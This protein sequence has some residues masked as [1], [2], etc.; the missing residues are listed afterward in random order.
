MQAK[1]FKLRMVTNLHIGSGESNFNFIDNQVQRDPI[2]EYPN[3]HSSGLKGALR[4]FFRGIESKNIIEF[5]G[6]E[7]NSDSASQGGLS[8]IEGKLLA[9]P[10]RSNKKSY[11]LGTTKEIIKEYIEFAK[12][13]GKEYEIDLSKIN[14]KGKEKVCIIGEKIAGITIE[15]FEG[16]EIIAEASLKEKLKEILGTEDIVIMEETS[17]KEEIAK[18]LPIIARNYLKN[19]ISDN[20][21]YEEVVPREAVFYTAIINSQNLENSLFESFGKTIT[22][23]LVQIGANATIGYG[24]TKFIEVK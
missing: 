17:F 7:S 5:F 24:F 19:G 3:I 2:T 6:G 12:M 4:E 16:D 11:L 20:L 13:F 18:R 10:V 8:F 23:N 22:E 14:F 15:S 21:W 9:L 1:L